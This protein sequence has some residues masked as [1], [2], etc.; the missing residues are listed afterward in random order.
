MQF[1]KPSIAPLLGGE[2]SSSSSYSSSLLPVSHLS[3]SLLSSISSD[4]IGRN[5]P[6]TTPFTSSSSSPSPAPSSV[7]KR[8]SNDRLLSSSSLSSSFR[9]LLYADFAATGRGL[10]RVEKFVKDRVLPL[11]GNTHTQ[12]SATGRHAAHLLEESRHILKMYMNADHRYGLIFCGNGASGAVTKFLQ[13]L[14]LSSSS[15]VKKRH[16]HP[17][18]SNSHDHLPSRRYQK[19]PPS[20]SSSPSS[21]SCSSSSCCA[22][23][24]FSSSPSSSYLSSFFSL[25]EEDRWGSYLCRACGS[26]LKTAAHARRHMN[27]SHPLSSSSA[28]SSSLD[29]KIDERRELSSSSSSPHPVRLHLHLEFLVDPTC[30]HSSFLPFREL[31]SS[32]SSFSSSSSS[33]LS[34]ASM[35]CPPGEHTAAARSNEKDLLSK[36]KS[37]KD[38][39]REEEEEEEK[40]AENLFSYRE[41][42]EKAGVY[43]DSETRERKEAAS[44]KKKRGGA[45]EE[46]EEDE[47]EEEDA[48]SGFSGSD[49]EEDEE[50]ELEKAKKSI[51]IRDGNV[52]ISIGFSFLHLDS[53]TAMLSPVS[54]YN[55]LRY[56]RQRIDAFNRLEAKRCS[57]DS[58]ERRKKDLSQTLSNSLPATQT[59]TEKKTPLSSSSSFSSSSSSSESFISSP[60][61]HVLLPVCIFSAVSNVTGLISPVPSSSSSFSSFSSLSS[62][63]IASV[64]ALNRL[65]HRFGGLAC[66]DYAGASSHIPI[67]VYNRI[68][69]EEEEDE[70]EEEEGER[71]IRKRK[72]DFSFGDEG[73]AMQEK[74]DFEER[75][76]ETGEKEKEEGKEPVSLLSTLS[77]SSSLSSSFPGS[78]DGCT[79][80]VF[81]SAHKLLGGPGSSGVLVLRKDLLLSDVPAHPGGGCVYLVSGYKAAVYEL[82]RSENREEAG[83]PNL[84]SIVR[85]A[86]SIRFLQQLPVKE[87]RSREERLTLK[88]LHSLRQHERIEI[89][90]PLSPRV[91]IISFLIRYGNRGPPSSSLSSSSSSSPSYSLHATRLSEGGRG[92]YL[93]HNFVTALLNDLFGIQVR[94]G[95]LCASPYTSFLLSIHPKLLECLENVL[96]TTGQDIFRPGVVRLSIHGLM[97][98]EEEVDKILSALLWVASNGW[99]LMPKYE[100]SPETGEWKVKGYSGR[101]EEEARIWISNYSFLPPI[102]HCE[103]EKDRDGMK[104]MTS[105]DQGVSSNSS[106]SSSSGSPLSSLHFSSSPLSSSSP[107]LADEHEEMRENKKPGEEE[108]LEEMLDFA[109]SILTSHLA[110]FKSSSSP[111]FHLLHLPSASCFK[112]YRLSDLNR[113]LSSC[114]SSSF[115]P[116]AMCKDGDAH[117]KKRSSLSNGSLASEDEEKKRKKEKEEE[118]KRDLSSSLSTS[119]LERMTSRLLWFALPADAAFSI[120]RCLATQGDKTKARI[121]KQSNRQ[122]IYQTQEKEEDEEEK[123]NSTHHTPTLH[124]DQLSQSS[125]SSFPSSSSSCY[126]SFSE[127]RRSP[128]VSLP[129]YRDKGLD[130]YLYEEAVRWKL[131]DVGGRSQGKKEAYRAQGETDEKED[132]EKRGDGEEDLGFDL[133]ERSKRAA[134]ACFHVRHFKVVEEEELKA[135]RSYPL[136]APFRQDSFSKSQKKKIEKLRPRSNRHESGRVEEE[137]R[138]EGA[139]EEIQKRREEERTD[140]ENRIILGEE[141]ETHREVMKEEY[142][143][144]LKEK[145]GVETGVIECMERREDHT[146]QNSSHS[147]SSSSCSTL[148]DTRVFRQNDHEEEEEKK[149]KKKKKIVSSGRVDA[150]ERE[151]IL[152][153]QDRVHH[154]REE[155]KDAWIAKLRLENEALRKE[156]EEERTKVTNLLLSHPRHR[157]DHRHR[158]SATQEE[159]KVKEEEEEEKKEERMEG[160]F[161][162]EDGPEQQRERLLNKKIPTNPSTDPVSP[163]SDHASHSSS[164]SSSSSTPSSR[165]AR[166]PSS[167]SST[168]RL[169][170]PRGLRRTVGEAIREFNMIR[171]GD[172]LLV[173]VSGGKDSLTLLH[174]LR[175]LQRRAPIH[176]DLAAATVDPVTPEFNPKPLIPYMQMLG[177]KY[178]YLRLPIMA[179][180]KTHMGQRQSICA[181]CSRLKRG[182]LYSCMRKH[183]Y[184]VL[185]LGQHLDD[186]CESFLMSALHNGS[187]NTMKAHYVIR[188]GD[189]RVCRPLI[190]TREKETSAFAV[191]N[192][193]PLIAD[194]CPACFAAPKERHRM[195]L[196]LSEQETEFP[197]VFQNLLKCV[198]PLISISAAEGAEEDEEEDEEEKNKRKKEKERRAPS[199]MDQP[200]TSLSRAQ[201]SSPLQKHE[202]EEEKKCGSCGES[203]KIQ[204]RASSQ[205]I[206]EDLPADQATV[207]NL[208]RHA[209][210]PALSEKD[211]HS[212]ECKKKKMREENARDAE[213]A[214]E[215]VMTACGINGSS[216]CCYRK[217]SKRDRED[218]ED[219]KEER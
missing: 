170:I 148:A 188:K 65:V 125:S 9:P 218:E 196:L 33:S 60:V 177:V 132:V 35:F 162:R 121:D 155:E 86:A 130:P 111:S 128:L 150:E 44:K 207:E 89:V 194:N 36:P 217:A 186:I 18:I 175:D 193:L 157:L 185:V 12:E 158:A 34:S 122:H 214:A 195:K 140:A 134:N 120:S 45:K 178:H 90:G 129:Y 147:L 82:D 197:Q 96:L 74:K 23:P 2:K 203:P 98:E 179:L 108:S 75:R 204:E 208:L 101:R 97:R 59:G 88:L 182:L 213:E 92:V 73:G 112:G 123:K 78:C 102:A 38:R 124:E 161:N 49:Y 156:I 139:R 107:C 168:V 25:F 141:K 116:E 180:A 184:N 71:R 94:G 26:R 4:V 46:E 118:K 66:W 211:M 210:C 14:L 106:S 205:V 126:S 209:G 84:L 63:S 52:D 54:L 48:S 159:K 80:V 103:E 113:E 206:E 31:A 109:D 127:G 143:P 167:S 72:V 115:S 137:V 191:A 81:F 187:L 68:E 135:V 22:S 99:K 58:Q 51:K 212:R 8:E 3:S 85:A 172:R 133:S 117:V 19:N 61:L 76:S 152:S 200:S 146:H 69:E 173:G 87:I 32:S 7:K 93:H 13:I 174:I 11:Y 20:S 166:F 64:G 56:L 136:D 91:G 183:G 169:K 151:E 41:E 198:K 83:S 189:L 39:G 17:H 43:K 95:C 160:P 27:S 10:Y 67:D 154:V 216:A 215:L 37:A 144:L 42:A 30:H 190:R 57:R 104:D 145:N 53:R 201:S 219:R 47:K 50:E 142:A 164:L 16:M 70:R 29:G 131:C 15:Y 62:M 199:G 149:S 77:S 171:E 28:S 40:E 114:S 192:R 138:S 181:F 79:D 6:L 21:S 55:R 1:N 24:C 163:S 202:K 119:M 165:L 5:F 100:I 176:F 110:S 153:S 105:L